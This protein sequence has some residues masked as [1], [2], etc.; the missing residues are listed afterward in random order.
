MTHQEKVA[1]IYAI[2]YAGPVL[3]IAALVSFRLAGR[4]NRSFR[5]FLP[6]LAVAFA[7]VVGIG[8]VVATRY[9]GEA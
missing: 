3:A 1:L 9:I 8:L 2:V 4:P 5:A 7:I 6:F